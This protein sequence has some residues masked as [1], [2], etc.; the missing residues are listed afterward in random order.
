MSIDARKELFADDLSILHCVN[1]DFGQ[2]SPLF[3]ILVGNVR[4]VLHDESIVRDEWVTGSKTVNFHCVHPPVD[5]A[6]DTLFPAR[7]R[8]AAAHAKGFYAH[9]VVVVKRVERFVSGLFADQVHHSFS[10]FLSRHFPSLL[11]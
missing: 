2:F 4:I 3:R 5:F 6:A 7:F 1:A 10:N 8:R 11:R 9:N